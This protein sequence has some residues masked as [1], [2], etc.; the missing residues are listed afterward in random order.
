MHDAD[1]LDGTVPLG[2]LE[3]LTFHGPASAGA[4]R[5][6]ALETAALIDRLGYRRLWVTEH[7]ARA[8]ASTNPLLWMAALAVVTR[9]VRLGAAVSLIR[10]RDPYLLAED[11]ATVAQLAGDRIDVGLGRGDVSGPG[12]EVLDRRCAD[13]A[14]LDAAVETLFG[15]LAGEQPWIAPCPHPVQRWLHGASERSAQRAARGGHDYCHGLFFDPDLDTCLRALE[16]HREQQPGARRAVAIAV[17]AND[18]PAAADRDAAIGGV[19]VD[20]AGTP[21]ACADRIAELRSLLPIDEVVI[22][23]QSRDVGDHR[24][25]LAGIAERMRQTLRAGAGTLVGATA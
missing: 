8:A 22:T 21:A 18:D 12:T 9:R 19:V 11:L 20:V 25:A 4:A 10:I 2:A 13:D 5:A 7:H 17:V 16:S 14:A 6:A 24:R 15:A 23:E 3:L 1:D